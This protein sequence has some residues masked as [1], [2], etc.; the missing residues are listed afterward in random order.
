MTHYEVLIIDK[1]C[2]C[3]SYEKVATF[4]TLEEAQ[5]FVGDDKNYI[6][7]KEEDAMTA[8]EFFVWLD[9]LDKEDELR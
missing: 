6:I 4:S 5:K 3:C 9:E 1:G 2:D 7:E 8:E